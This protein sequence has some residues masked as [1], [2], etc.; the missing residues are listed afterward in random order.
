MK[1]PISYYGGKQK[2]ARTI[3]SLI[4]THMLYCEPFLGGGAVF[5]TKPQSEVEVLNDTNRELINFYR[6][7]QQDFTSLEKEIRIS[8][9]SR[10]L[11]RKASVVYEN[12]DM[13][14]DIKR[15]WAVWILSLQTF[16]AKLDGPWGYDRSGNTTTKKITNKR[17]AFTEDYAIRLQNVQL[18]CADALYVIRSRD[19]DNSFF[20]CDPPYYNAN[21]GHYDGYSI[22]DFENLLAI[23]SQVKGKFL[24]SSYPSD[25]LT[26]Y[27]KENSWS[28]QVFEQGVS[29]NAKGG[30]MKRKWEVLTANY[31]I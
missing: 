3:V 17:E 16:A 14:S 11:H 13:F 22:Q 21:C 5:F 8:L 10:D 27:T 23:L 20:Y 4:P 6:V 18:E 24:L 26:R 15:A 9:H 31:Q 19:S 28:T 2:L 7:V 12:P 25:L 29:V 30:Y 1:T